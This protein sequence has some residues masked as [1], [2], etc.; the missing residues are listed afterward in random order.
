M[1][2]VALTGGEKGWCTDIAS[3]VKKPISDAIQI[4]Q[5]TQRDND[6]WAEQKGQLEAE[7]KTLEE[8]HRQLLET[9]TRLQQQ[10][11]THTAKVKDLE[12]QKTEMARLSEEILPFLQAVLGRLTAFVD[13]DLPFLA[14]ERTE[15]L[16]RLKTILNDPACSVGEKYRKT[17]EALIIEVE[18]GNTIEVYDDKI[19][20]AD[21][22]I[23]AHVFRLGRISMFFE[24]LD[25][26]T[27]GIYDPSVGA[28]KVLPVKY[29]TD[30]GKAIEIGMKRRSIELLT[31]PLGRITAQ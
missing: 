9:Q 27:T 19:T 21:E 6:R 26:K 12:T 3:Q 16:K 24:T 5:K 1:L 11:N 17:M 7:Y 28:W 13:S 23:L 8:M 31:L 20:I 18:Y 4:R 10:Q 14:D 25:H 15:R 29:N 30:I 2:F 22:R